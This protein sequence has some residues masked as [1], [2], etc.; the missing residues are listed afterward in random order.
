MAEHKYDRG[1]GD[2]D[3]NGILTVELAR[4][5][6]EDVVSLEIAHGAT[7]ASLTADQARAVGRDLLEHADRLDEAAPGSE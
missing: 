2:T 5:Y 7:F 1:G 3:D 4:F 6:G